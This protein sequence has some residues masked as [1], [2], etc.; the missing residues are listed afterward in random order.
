MTKARPTA[1]AP[2]PI[3]PSTKKP[4]RVDRAEQKEIGKPETRSEQLIAMMRTRQGATAQELASA[5]GWQLHSVRGFI[6]G[7]VKKRG[8]LEVSAAKVEGL[9]RYRVRTRKDLAA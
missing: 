5:V 4:V 9:T 2:K 6:S 3:I 1:R 7:T 8:D